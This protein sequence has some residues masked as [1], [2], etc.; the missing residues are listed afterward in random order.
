[1]LE[2]RQPRCLSLADDDVDPGEAAILE[3]LGFEALAMLPLEAGAGVW[4]LIEIYRAGT[5]FTDEDLEVASATIAR[6]ARLLEELLAGP[7]SR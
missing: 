4:A 3:A 5:A 6:F 7:A 2:S 1:M